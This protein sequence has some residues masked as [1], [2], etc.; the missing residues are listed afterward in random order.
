MPRISGEINPKFPSVMGG[1]WPFTWLS[2]GAGVLLTS[3]PEA[4]ADAE[5]VEG[6]PLER[7]GC[8]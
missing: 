2:G 4:V 8:R 1:V 3:D 6:L 5:Q 7:G